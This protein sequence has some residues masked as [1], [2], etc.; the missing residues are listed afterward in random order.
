MRIRDVAL[1]VTLDECI[2]RELV[3]ITVFNQTVTKSGEFNF[4]TE[5]I[6]NMEYQTYSYYTLMCINL[7]I[8]ISY[9]SNKSAS[10]MY[11]AHSRVG[12]GN[13]VL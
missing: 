4:A 11:P 13:L 5:L 12:R 7:H 10:C 8:K 3:P 9:K 2:D 6:C 1:A